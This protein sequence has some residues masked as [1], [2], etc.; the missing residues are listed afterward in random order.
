MVRLKG[1]RARS[2][3]LF[4]LDFNSKMVRLKGDKLHKLSIAALN[5]NSKMVRLKGVFLCVVAVFAV[6][7]QFQNGAVK[8]RSKKLKRQNFITQMSRL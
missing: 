6:Q 7:F 3:F 1:H 8:S 5:F 4:R 2:I